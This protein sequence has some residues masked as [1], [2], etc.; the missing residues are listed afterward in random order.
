[1]F[2]SPVPE[3]VEEL[4]RLSRCEVTSDDILAFSPGDPGYND[5]VREW[6]QILRSGIVPLK[7]N[8][9]LT[10]V[11]AMTS[12]ADPTSWSGDVQRFLAF[13]R[14]TSAVALTLIHRSNNC[15]AVR[16][17]VYLARDL[18]VDL[19][20]FY[21]TGAKFLSTLRAVFRDTRTLLRSTRDPE[22]PFITL[23]LLILAQLDHDWTS[24]EHAAEQLLADEQE[25]RGFLGALFWS[26]E[27]LFG[28]TVYDQ[29]TKDWRR[30]IA[31]LQNPSHHEA[32]AIIIDALSHA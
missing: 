25:A 32:T 31:G 11:I 28:L 30:M 15:E 23:G 3:S 2:E 19:I 20:D 29:L 12:W 27:F 6:T 5:Y 9:D 13:R 14:F 4:F 22:F 17:P 10:E 18:L 1:M 26:P 16:P 7:P 24:A 8:F 21:P